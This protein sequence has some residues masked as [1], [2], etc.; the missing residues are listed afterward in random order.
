LKTRKKLLI[1]HCYGVYHRGTFHTEY[2]EY[3]NIYKAQLTKAVNL[4]INGDYDVLIISGGYT[5][6]EVEKSEARGMLDWVEDLGLWPA[7]T[8]KSLILLEEYARDSFENILFSVCRFYQ[9]FNEFP[10]SVTSCTWEFN[11]ERFKIFAKKLRIPNFNVVPVG[12]REDQE[13]VA[14]KWT[15]LA[16]RDPLYIKQADSEEKYLRRNPWKR[17]HPYSQISPVFRILFNTLSEIKI[18]KGNVKELE[19]ILPWR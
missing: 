4:L 10:A 16:K 19:N 13:K 3:T 6:I 15:D 9:F 14:Q 11:V 18:K 12:K 7:K 8:R 17:D 1:L 2:P 5:K